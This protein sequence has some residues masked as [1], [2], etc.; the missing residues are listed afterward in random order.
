[1][2]AYSPIRVVAASTSAQAD[3][4]MVPDIARGGPVL[5]HGT[6]FNNGPWISI[7]A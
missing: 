1:M 3:D 4:F 7:E 6:G 5:A 2:H